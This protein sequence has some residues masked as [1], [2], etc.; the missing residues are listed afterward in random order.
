MCFKMHSPFFFSLLFFVSLVADTNRHES[1]PLFDGFPPVFFC[2]KF[3]KNDFLLY[4]APEND[5]QW[6]AVAM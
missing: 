1:G 2:F 5:L 4:T 6:I 3:W